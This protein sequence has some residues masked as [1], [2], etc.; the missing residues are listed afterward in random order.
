MA[1]IAI[2]SPKQRIFPG[3]SV[4]S[5]GFKGVLLETTVN[6]SVTVHPL[7]SSAI[8]V[9]TSLFLTNNPPIEVDVETVAIKLEVEEL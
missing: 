1:V 2:V 5:D 6:V 9:I 8:T 7:E 4:L 3:I